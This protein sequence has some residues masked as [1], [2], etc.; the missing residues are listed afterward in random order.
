MV[1][2][3]LGNKRT[4]KK[5]AE[6]EMNVKKFH[7]TFEF[8]CQ[9]IFLFCS[10]FISSVFWVLSLVWHSRIQI[11]QFKNIRTHAHW[12]RVNFETNKETIFTYEEKFIFTQLEF[13]NF[14][15]LCYLFLIEN[16]IEKLNWNEEFSF[17]LFLLFCWDIF[18]V[19]W[20]EQSE[21]FA[22]R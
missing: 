20:D 21:R 19:V 3:E 18:G 22:C 15:L 16:K 14:F 11:I 6:A 10:C 4:A 12:L 1:S 17:F 5:I 9:F 7:L 13:T 8:Y 2:S